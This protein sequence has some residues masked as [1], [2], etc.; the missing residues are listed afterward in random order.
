MNPWDPDRLAK[1]RDILRFGLWIFVF[2]H[3]VLAGVFSVLWVSRFL[4]HLW[5]WCGRV[6]FGQE[7]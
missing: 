6:L 7:W 1:L 3:C 5:G 2:I 4:W